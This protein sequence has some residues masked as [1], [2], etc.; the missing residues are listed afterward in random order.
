[1]KAQ[2]KGVVKNVTPVNQVS[3]NFR[4]CEVWVETPGEYSQTIP[5]QFSQDKADAV[6]SVQVGQEITIEIDLRGRIWTGADGVEKCFGSNE[7][8]KYSA[9]STPVQEEAEKGLPF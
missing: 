7:G 8:W 1:M 5:V 4:K 2:V 3:E 9:E 6:Q